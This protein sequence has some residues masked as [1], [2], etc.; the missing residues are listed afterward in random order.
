MTVKINSRTY[1]VKDEKE[2][3]A[4]AKR[5]GARSFIIQDGIVSRLCLASYVDAANFVAEATKAVDNKK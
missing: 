4:K 5:L 1:K 3:R 2:A